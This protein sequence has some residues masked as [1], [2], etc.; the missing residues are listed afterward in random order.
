MFI[1]PRLLQGCSSQLRNATMRSNLVARIRQTKRERQR[2]REREREREGGGGG[3][4][5]RGREGRQVPPWRSVFI[6]MFYIQERGD[7]K[8]GGGRAPLT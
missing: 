5:G 7:E 3:G 1:P 8:Q 6:A 2:E 4:G